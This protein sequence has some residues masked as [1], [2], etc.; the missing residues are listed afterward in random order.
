MLFERNSAYFSYRED[1]IIPFALQFLVD[2]WKKI[3]K[4]MLSVLKNKN[5]FRTKF[6]GIITFL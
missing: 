2:E 6:S 4:K 1:I 3:V 5:T